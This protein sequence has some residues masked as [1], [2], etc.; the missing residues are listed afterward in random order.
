MMLLT[1]TIQCENRE[2]ESYKGIIS[3]FMKTGFGY[4]IQADIEFTM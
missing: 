2:R 3:L 4:V 1:S